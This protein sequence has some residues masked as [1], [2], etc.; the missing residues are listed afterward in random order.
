M[1]RTINCLVIDKGLQYLPYNV[2]Y[3]KERYRRPVPMDFYTSGK[4]LIELKLSK[5]DLLKTKGIESYHS[6]T[7]P[8]SL[9]KKLK[10]VTQCSPKQKRNSKKK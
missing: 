10:E 9:Y 8:N 4:D 1:W 3:Q 2:L 7:I 6:I 5:K